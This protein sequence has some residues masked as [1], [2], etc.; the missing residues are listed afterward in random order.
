[1]LS[2]ARLAASLGLSLGDP[3][4]DTEKC[5]RFSLEYDYTGTFHEDGGRD[6][7]IEWKADDVPLRI[8]ASG[9][10]WSGT[11]QLTF[12]RWQYPINGHTDCSIADAGYGTARP[13]TATL[14]LS[15]AP[16]TKLDP[17]T[18]REIDDPHPPAVKLVL[19]PGSPYDGI[20]ITCGTHTI[21]D[22]TDIY[23]NAWE[24]LHGDEF[25]L[26]TRMFTLTNWAT[27]VTEPFAQYGRGR[28]STLWG[29]DGSL[30]LTHT[31]GAS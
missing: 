24:N 22:A 2:L 18:G 26:D 27:A 8:D 19:D 25:S 23:W 11:Q 7:V 13:L 28:D 31:P 15:F 16:Q 10:T 6:G 4:A 12:V 9:T 30:A 17:A 29:D 5:A 21:Y 3:L 20:N 1:M 14:S